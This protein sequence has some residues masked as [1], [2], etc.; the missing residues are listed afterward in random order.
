MSVEIKINWY[1]PEFDFLDGEEVDRLSADYFRD[2][3]AWMQVEYDTVREAVAA[4]RSQ[5]LGRGDDG[6]AI[7]LEICD[8]VETDNIGLDDG[9]PWR[10]W[11]VVHPSDEPAGPFAVDRH[12]AIIRFVR[13]MNHR[14]IPSTEALRAWNMWQGR[15]FD[16]RLVNVTPAPAGES[17]PDCVASDLS[18][19]R[20]PP[21]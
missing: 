21:G 16:V 17:G 1:T 5:Y 13:S 3:G 9:P 8:G 18:G 20:I 7:M 14:R 11:M 10:G 15:G 4:A 19:P 2:R 6:T 12:S